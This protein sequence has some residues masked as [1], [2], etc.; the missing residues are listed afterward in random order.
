MDVE[1]ESGGGVSLTPDSLSS[2]NSS[3]PLSGG[4]ASDDVPPPWARALIGT[5]QHLSTMVE[6]L[7]QKS[8]PLPSTPRSRRTRGEAGIFHVKHEPKYRDTDRTE[9]MVRLLNC[10]YHAFLTLIGGLLEHGPE[11]N[12]EFVRHQ[13]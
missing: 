5:V 10:I 13:S 7:E 11:E 3:A 9:M 4:N 12:A 2:D 6:S 1:V 8:V